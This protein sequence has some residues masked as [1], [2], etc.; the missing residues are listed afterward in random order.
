[1]KTYNII[2]LLAIL[3]LFWSCQEDEKVVLQ[4]PDSFVLNVPKY[5]SGIYD[6]KNTETIEFTT[7]QPD[8]GFTAVA[9]YSV[10]VS[11]SQ[12]F[13]EAVTL[14]GTYTHAKFNMNAADLALALVGLHGVTE[15]SAYPT[16]PHPL[17][18]RLSSVLNAKK[19][20]S[21][22][23]QHHYPS[24]GKRLLCA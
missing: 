20:G 11:L 6:L 24:K 7:S 3:G 4:Q 14:P 9:I 18:V 16:D 23:I 13:S 21:S 8:Y 17:Y 1:M 15:E 19:R 12:D 22:K 5:A 2:V 10:E